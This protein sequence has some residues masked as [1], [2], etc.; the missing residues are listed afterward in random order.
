ME[1]LQEKVRK[2]VNGVLDNL[3]IPTGKVNN[4]Q[5]LTSTNTSVQSNINNAY[6]TDVLNALAELDAD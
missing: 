4:Q 5:K 1:I 3:K 2:L 6:A